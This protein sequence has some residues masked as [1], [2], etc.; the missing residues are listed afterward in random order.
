MLIALTSTI[1]AVPSISSNISFTPAEVGRTHM[2]IGGVWNGTSEITPANGDQFSITYA[3]AP[4]AM[5]AFDFAPSATIPSG[6]SIV[7][8][9]SIAFTGGS[10]CQPITLGVSVN[11]TGQFAITPAGWNF[12]PDCEITI[13]FE[14]TTV[15]T[16]SAGTFAIT[17]NHD[18]ANSNNGPLVGPISGAP[19]NIAV[20]PGATSLTKTPGL[21]T[22]AAGESV[23]FD[24]QVCNTGLGGLF[25]VVIDE[26]ASSPTNAAGSLELTSLTQTA[27]ATPLATGASP[28]LTLPYL[29]ANECFTVDAQAT[30]TG[31]ESIDNI[32]SSADRTGSSLSVLASVNLAL[33][34]P[35]ITYPS[36]TVNVPA[37]GVGNIA[38]P[39]Q[40]TGNGDAQ[41][42]RIFFPF[43]SDVIVSNVDP[44]W[45][46]SGNT[47]T[48]IGDLG[49]GVG[50]IADSAATSLT[51]DVGR[52]QICPAPDG[53]NETIGTQALYED[54][55]GNAYQVP[56]VLETVN[57]APPAE[58]IS[59]VKGP[60]G[61]FNRRFFQG[62][63]SFFTL[64]VTEEDLTQLQTDPLIVRD[65][66]PAG[67]ENYSITAPVGTSFDCGG[68]TN[69]SPGET[70]IWSIPNSEISGTIVLRIDFD[71][72]TT[73]PCNT[74]FIENV[75]ETTFGFTGSN[76][77]ETL[78]SSTGIS[79][80]IP[81][82]I[83]LPPATAPIY[84]VSGGSAADVFETGLASLDGTQDQLL[85]EGGFL[86][87]SNS[88]SFAVG[89]VEVWAGSSY[90]DNFGN[91]SSQAIVPGS[92]EVI[93][94]GGS[95]QPVPLG[96]IVSSVGSLEIDLAFLADPGFFGSASVA[97]QEVQILYQTTVNDSEIATGSDMERVQS[98]ASFNIA[99]GGG[100]SASSACIVG[101]GLSVFSA[102]L[103]Y[104]IARR[105]LIPQINLPPVVEVC[106]I[107]PVT[108]TSL[109]GS[110]SFGFGWHPLITLLNGSD[111]D[112]DTTQ[113]IAF[114]G[115]FSTS[116]IIQT[117]NAENP[118]FEF[119]PE[120]LLQTQNSSISF[121]V[122]LPAGSSTTPTELCASLSY[123]DTQT[124][125]TPGKNF[126][127]SDSCDEPT[128]VTAADL[129]IL[130]SPNNI[131]IT[132]DR[133]NFT[134]NVI[135]GG[136]GTSFNTILENMLPVGFTAN[137]AA[138]N[139]AN[140]GSLD[141]SV[142]ISGQQMLWELGDL[143][144]GQSVM[145]N[146]VADVENTSSCADITAQNQVNAS[147]GC[148]GVNHQVTTSNSPN[149]EFLPGQILAV[150]DTSL[151]EAGV[152]DPGTIG[153]DVLIIRN[154]GGT[155]VFDV[156][157][158]E[159]L[160]SLTSGISPAAA[161][162]YEFRTRDGI[163]GAFSQHF[164]R[165]WLQREM[166][167]AAL[168]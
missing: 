13:D 125:I 42:V 37:T 86:Q 74:G 113:P 75:A 32:A 95:A 71:I 62:D 43:P 133:T 27:P 55:C 6:F 126:D 120:P 83:G 141:D 143:T 10:N 92:V 17:P 152:C 134:I 29:G 53:S 84:S 61:N 63:S 14:L 157:V 114:G 142:T 59:F 131:Q 69:C 129:Q 38:L 130:I 44:N 167:P 49:S 111:Y 5:R 124:I 166:D 77:S 93:L 91:L 162:N 85:G 151:T 112:F 81:T 161:P 136:A 76:C 144:P 104:D 89:A 9:P 15:A 33:T 28:I 132:G 97:G 116:T 117:L 119:G 139:T 115:D 101:G 66:L 24:V 67:L 145:I 148:G 64:E 23:N 16:A 4:G 158:E 128:V 3:N 137:E 12:R 138:T 73:D 26:S 2:D 156:Q 79:I 154:T 46:F 110:E 122:V 1:H 96:S 105:S 45:S 50:I 39:I 47:F 19:L 18:F 68:D 56:V 140:A 41:N 22:A 57:V 165:Q 147:W 108:I 8:T 34:T 36:M 35:L 40:N 168:H 100:G 21:Q 99:S 90:T 107:T 123:D 160:D 159:V 135:N 98:L 70:L 87:F 78:S 51:F 80:S 58:A 164:N 153:R 121:D 163:T 48:L 155:S 146:V 118:S 7:G 94:N 72:P 109:Q 52:A 54:L 65:L 20:L 82:P 127:A 30:V 60:E 25:D 106:G 11:A 149:F 103:E 31:C 102:V 88:V 150:H